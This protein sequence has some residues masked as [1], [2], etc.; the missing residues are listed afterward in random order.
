MGVFYRSRSAKAKREL[1]LARAGG[2]ELDENTLDCG[3]TTPLL[4]RA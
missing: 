4:L 3:G 2:F 1:E